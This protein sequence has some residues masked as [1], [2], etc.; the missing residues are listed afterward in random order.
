MK[1]TRYC[2]P[3][4]CT[5]VTDVTAVFFLQ[6][7]PENGT[8]E[9]T[10]V[11]T[12]TQQSQPQ[13]PASVPT[14]NTSPTVP[15][16]EGPASLSAEQVT[17]PENTWLH[18]SVEKKQRLNDMDVAKLVIIVDSSV[19]N[20]NYHSELIKNNTIHKFHRSLIDLKPIQSRLQSNWNTVKV[21]LWP[22]TTALQ[23]FEAMSASSYKSTAVYHKH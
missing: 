16:S 11:V 22:V 4:R 17:L 21:I 12:P 19:K 14:Q 7:I 5:S 23:E 6:S 20:P 10:P 18:R 15:S 13:A 2:L 8:A 3:L 1:C 9:A